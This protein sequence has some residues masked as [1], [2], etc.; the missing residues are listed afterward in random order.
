[1]KTS[2][3]LKYIKAHDPEGLHED[4]TQTLSELAFIEDELHFLRDLIT[5]NTLELIVGK[6]FEESRKLA[7]K[8]SSLENKEKALLKEL[9]QHHN[10][11]E[12]LLDDIEVPN[13]VKDYK[14]THYKLMMKVINFYAEVKSV[15]RNIFKIIAENRKKN[16]EKRLL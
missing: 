4:T 9:K 16:K 15:K 6:P 3:H 1:M 2:T 7:E 11:L 5:E 8:L 14:D 13:E 12:L 10:N